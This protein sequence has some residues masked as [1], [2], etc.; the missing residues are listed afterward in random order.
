MFTEYSRAS[1][2]SVG[3]NSTA[4]SQSFSS[5]Q[6]GSKSCLLL[7]PD[8]VRILVNVG[9]NLAVHSR[10]T[11]IGFFRFFQGLGERPGPCKYYVSL[12]AVFFHGGNTGS[13]PVGD[14]K[15]FQELANNRRN[16]R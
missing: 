3:R 13:N 12:Y 6:Y 5:C 16:F 8:V 4:K 14:A 7:V 9:S 10:Y 15:P 1:E 11:V 2:S